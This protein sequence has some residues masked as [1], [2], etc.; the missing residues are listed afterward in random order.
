M[1][2]RKLK[3]L[4]FLKLLFTSFKVRQYQSDINNHNNII[5]SMITISLMGVLQKTQKINFIDELIA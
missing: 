2:W 3:F 5:L 4:E 1:G